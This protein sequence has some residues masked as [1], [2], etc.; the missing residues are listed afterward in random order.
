ALL[1][2]HSG[3]LRSNHP[4]SRPRAGCRLIRLQLTG[5]R[6]ERCELGREL[7]LELPGVDALSLGVKQAPLQQLELELELS[8]RLVQPIMLGFD[9]GGSLPLGHQRSA[10][11]GEYS[12]EL[13]NS[14]AR[15]LGVVD[16]A[17]VVSHNSHLSGF[18]RDVDP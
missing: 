11:G 6:I 17:R 5:E 7:K 14:S 18:D 3:H 1:S 9:V 12:L 8:K 16:R 10:F 4:C 13:E 2:I 15:R